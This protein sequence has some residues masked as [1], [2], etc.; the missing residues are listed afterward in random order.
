MF[1]LIILRGFTFDFCQ[2]C[3]NLNF[4]TCTGA[5]DWKTIFLSG[6]PK[7]GSS[8]TLT[9][10]IHLVNET[11]NISW[12]RA[13]FLSSSL[14]KSVSL[15]RGIW[16]RNQSIRFLHQISDSPRFAKR[17]NKFNLSRFFKYFFVFYV[18]TDLKFFNKAQ[19]ENFRPVRGWSSRTRTPWSLNQNCDSPKFS[20]SPFNFDLPR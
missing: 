5:D 1:Q 14:E 11:Q 9:T 7:T 13:W 2:Q 20:E 17:A 3:L 4:H 12:L 6:A 8:K 10:V 18:T 15:V 16:L 19:M